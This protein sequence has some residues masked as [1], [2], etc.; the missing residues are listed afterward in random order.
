MHQLGCR[1][2]G[3][4]LWFPEYFKL[5]QHLT[6]NSTNATHA[7]SSSLQ[8]NC[9]ELE[10]SFAAGNCAKIYLDTLLETVATVPGTVLGILTINL[11]GGRAQLCESRWSETEGL[12]APIVP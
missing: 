10:A 9:T 3:L 1:Y 11:V 4:Q 7:C 2:Y 8:L 12:Q 5:L 6:T